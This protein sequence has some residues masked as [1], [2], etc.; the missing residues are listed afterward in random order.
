MVTEKDKQ[1]TPESETDVEN[2]L[3]GLKRR[4]ETLQQELKARDAAITR[5]EMEKAA[6]EG[7]IAEMESTTA[8]AEKKITEISESLTKAV[9][10]YR[11]EVIRDNP[12][13][14][15]DLISG[16]NIEEI[17]ESLKKAMALVE[18]V[19]QEMEEEVARMRIPGG[20]P[21]R[22]SMDISALSPREKIQYAIGR[23]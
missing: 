1:E 13:V 7:E 8:D 20:A 11:E 5:L 16:E 2:E 3:E 21:Q 4:N 22:T 6:H 17:D 18:K 10:A 9:A 15:A 14:L 23:S 19:K 12:G